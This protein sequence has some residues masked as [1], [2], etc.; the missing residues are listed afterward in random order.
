MAIINHKL[1]I[2]KYFFHLHKGIF[3]SQQLKTFFSLVYIF[4]SAFQCIFE[5]S[6]TY[7]QVLGTGGLKGGRHIR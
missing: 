7:G 6:I 5:A 4:P 2:A 1:K 3:L